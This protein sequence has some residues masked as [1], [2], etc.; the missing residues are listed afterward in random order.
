M[1]QASG[2]SIFDNTISY[3]S[4]IFYT[5][6]AITPPITTGKSLKINNPNTT[7]KVIHT[8][9]WI[10][11]NNASPTQYTYSAWVKSNGTNPQAEINLFM[12]TATETGYYTLLDSQTIATSTNWVLVQKTFTVPANNKKI[13]IRLDNNTTGVLW[14]DDV[15]IVKTS[16]ILNLTHALS[17]TYNAFKAPVTL[18][19]TNKGSYDFLYNASN[20]RSVMYYGGLQTNKLQRQY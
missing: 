5:N 13:S 8:V 16:D 11:I 6:P 9:N 4:T 19:E 12:K 3:D 17:A 7:E 20:S 14:F 2:W 15:K 1:E 18:S 10:L